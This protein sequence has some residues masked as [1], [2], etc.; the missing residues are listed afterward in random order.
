[1]PHNVVFI[2]AAGDN[3]EL[4]VVRGQAASQEDLGDRRIA[5][6]EIASLFP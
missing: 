2:R 5:A 1:M 3:E 6:A 4:H